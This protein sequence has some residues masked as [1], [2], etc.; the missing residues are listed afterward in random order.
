M[1]TGPEKWESVKSLFEAAQ[2][3]PPGELEAFLERQSPDPEVR[4][5]VSRLLS[6]YHEAEGFL[7]T[8]AVGRLHADPSAVAAD[9][10]RFPPGEVLSGRF[11]IVEFLAAG[12]MGVVYKA[13][14]TEL[15]RFTALKFLPMDS[16][17]DAHA[18]ARL[19][20]EA[21]AASALNHPN[22]CT[23]YEIGHHRGQAFIAMEFLDGVTLKQRIAGEHMPLDLL[24]SLAVE[25]AD[26]LDAAHTAAIFHRDIKPANIF[27]TR[28]GHAKILDFGIAKWGGDN[29]RVASADDVASGPAEFAD[30]HAGR[31]SLSAVPSQDE[32][33]SVFTAPGTRAGTVAYMSP[34]QLEGRELDTRTDIFSFGVVLY[35]MA[36]GVRPF[37]GKDPAAIYAAVLNDA[38]TP[39]AKLRPDLPPK[40]EA[41]ILRALQKDRELRYQ[42]A[43]EMRV[44][45]QRLRTEQESGLHMMHVRT[46]HARLLW[47]W[48]LAGLAILLAVAAIYLRLG[49]PR[50]LTERDTVVVGDFLNYTGD[51]VFSDALKAGLA[52]DLGQSP[53]LNLLSEDQI[54][55]QLLFMGR[56][57]DANNKTRPADTSVSPDV[58]REVCRRTGS[59]ATLLGSIANIGSHYAITLKAMNCETGDSLDVEQEEADRREQV[60]A[61]LHE[62]A[63]GMRGKLGESLASVQKHDTPLEQATTSSLEALQAYSLA[64]KMFRTSGDAAAIPQ[65]KRALAL[66]PTFALALADLG[67]MY[68]NLDEAAP[69][70]EYLT[71]AYQL[72]ERV[73]ERERYSIDSHY[74]MNA[75]GELEKAEQVFEE[76]MQLYPRD[77]APYIDLGLVAGY[78]GHWDVALSTAQQGYG[79]KKDSFEVY[80]DL[81]NDY[82]YLDRLDEAQVVLDEAR[83]RKLDEPLLQN[84]YQL[85]FLR[86]D[87]QG[88]QRCLNAA[89]GKADV[90]SAIL[91]SQ[92][93]TDAFYGRLGKAREF[94]Q[95]AV[96]SAIVSGE[97]ETAAE[98]EVTAAL[99]EAEFG[100]RR[101]A[102]RHAEAAMDLAKTRDIQVAAAM[103]FARAGD[104]RGA[105]KIAEMLQKRFPSDT[106]LT[107]Y[108]VPSI[109]AA[110]AISQG[111]AATALDQLQVTTSYE[112]GGG[113]LPFSAGASMYPVYLRGLAFLAM[114]QWKQAAD[115]F[116][117][118]TDHRGLVWN[119][120]LG[121]LAQLEIGRAYANFDQAKAKTAYGDFA[122][123]WDHADAEIP[124]FSEAKNEIAKLQ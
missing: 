66:D 91:A 23:I 78:L 74:Y 103:A 69:C 29:R 113:I 102:R 82:M 45:L 37:Q 62:A 51:P 123:L 57:A 80:N 58:A 30:L 99:R 3:V 81:S 48:S 59:A 14:D 96:S 73:T 18:Q 104:P 42:H 108:W 33:D 34:E 72:R 24:L 9:F 46:K 109:R 124:I 47:G 12:G 92:A 64:N 63:K 107:K 43:S 77:L 114:K 50:K 44:D 22:I 27:I 115:E 85:A 60:L 122:A 121:A 119:S 88:M 31:G 97:K 110:I 4:S 117:K 21:Q 28:R 70:A 20:R 7:S 84:I 86:N 65:F 100:N 52:A 87:A 54:N 98:W 116:Q 75:T 76:W 19:Q 2:T 67:V 26:A 95:R 13:E 89:S 36:T 68:C 16:A 90:E 94:S 39:P 101:E 83:T 17:G 41:I 25:I 15:H 118:I 61:K 6:E 10:D 49:R 11:T 38:P 8:P 93:D 56:A 55:Q 32:I 5:E 106:L 111:N 120:P 79:L 112:R 71:R 105:Q 40:L 1:V 53:F 35:Q